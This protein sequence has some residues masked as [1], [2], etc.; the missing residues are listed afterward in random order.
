MTAD[1]FRIIR[2]VVEQS[3]KHSA[4]AAARVREAEVAGAAALDPDDPALKFLRD[5]GADAVAEVRG[6][7]GVG[8]RCSLVWVGDTDGCVLL[9]CV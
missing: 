7:V 4:A 6:C 5:W 1:Y 9:W 2:R 3:A 8:G